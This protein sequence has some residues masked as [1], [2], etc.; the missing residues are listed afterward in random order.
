[1]DTN[2]WIYLAN[3][4]NPKN[5]NYEDGLHFKLV[6]SLIKLIDSGDFI[7]LTND[8]IIEE[9]NRNKEAAKKLIEKHKKTVEGNEGSIKNI[10]K[11]L[12]H[13]DKIKLNDIFQKYTD[14]IQ[15]I[16]QDNERHI[17]EVE[18]LLVNK[19]L[20]IEIPNEV[21]IIAA[22]RAIKKMAPF[23]GDKSN[24]MA[25]AIIL[26]SSIEYLKKIRDKLWKEEEFFPSYPESIFVTNN[27]GDFANPSNENEVH[28][29]LK[30]LL[31]KV[32]MK[33]EMNIGKVINKAHVDLI[34]YEEIKQI[35]KDLDEEYWKSLTYCEECSP[36]PEK[37][38]VHNIIEFEEPIQ[39]KNELT[40]YY[41]PNQMKLFELQKIENS[42]G[43]EKIKKTDVDT[44]QLGSCTWCSSKYIKCQFCGGVNSIEEVLEDSKF[45]C[46]G[47]Y[48]VYEVV[49]NYIGNG[50]HEDKIKIIGIN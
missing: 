25:D 23:K 27:K 38:Y 10:K 33:Y 43:D 32:E 40:E 20:K 13:E 5:K 30:P 26:L 36:D 12:E 19:S 9:W 14:S 6:E 44:I 45:E 4:Y 50:M 42:E 39:I 46:E 8:I 35:E 31:E 18:E 21:K 49:S 17:Q 28:I 37:M 3:S 2:I 7:L 1:L 47:C 16:I 29:E 34:A 41:D 15:K 22:D 24:S 48:L 11:Q